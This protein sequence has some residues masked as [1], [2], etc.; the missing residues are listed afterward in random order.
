MDQFGA[1]PVS[2]DALSERLRQGQTLTIEGSAGVDYALFLDGEHF[3]LRQGSQNQTFRQL[4]VAV[5][6][7]VSSL[8]EFSSTKPDAVPTEEPEIDERIVNIIVE[9]L[10]VE[11]YEVTPKASFDDLQLD[12][13]GLDLLDM[14]VRLEDLFGIEISDDDVIQYM[15]TVGDVQRYL[16]R[17]EVL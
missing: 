9:V 16:M 2:F 11:P 4:E 3:V 6:T 17:R 12:G 1:L 10:H 7:L 13:F 5:L 8:G 14:V 15:E